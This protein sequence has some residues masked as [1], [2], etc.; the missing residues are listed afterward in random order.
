ME[1]GRYEAWCQQSIRAYAEENVKSG[2]WDDSD[3]ME[4]S[5]REFLGLL[6]NGLASPDHFIF[7]LFYDS[8]YLGY[9]WVFIDPG[10]AVPSAFIYDIEIVAEQRGKGVGK[11]TMRALEPWCKSL[12]LKRIALNVFAFNTA[13]IELYQ[14]MGYQ[15]TNFSMQKDI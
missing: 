2:R 4:R 12:N 8:L 1:P 7:E 15:T 3:A 10:A 11:A 5:E 6:P 13:A 14:G 9:L